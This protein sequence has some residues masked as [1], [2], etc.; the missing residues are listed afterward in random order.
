MPFEREHLLNAASYA[1]VS[2]LGG[3]R[4]RSDRSDQRRQDLLN[5][6]AQVGIF[7]QPREL[8]RVSSKCPDFGGMLL[9]L[10]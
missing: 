6:S 8:M 10:D 5:L 3:N 9:A 2:R 4:L 1:L 7:S